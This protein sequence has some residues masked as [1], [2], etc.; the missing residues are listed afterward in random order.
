MVD[1]QAVVIGLLGAAAASCAA[2]VML[3]LAHRVPP[4]DR[5]V[6]DT[7]PRLLRVFAPLIRMLAFYLGPRLSVGFR[8]RSLRQLQAAELDLVFLPQEWLA[9]RL[10]V[11]LV[12]IL[13][14]LLAARLGQVGSGLLAGVGA[15]VFLW[16]YSARWLGEKRAAVQRRVLRDLP[17]YLDVLTLAVEAG[18]SLTV[19]IGW[20][21]EKTVDGPLRRGF[22]RALR[23]VRAG[24]T[25]IDALR[26]FEHRFAMPAITSLVS[27]LVSAEQTGASVGQVLRAQAEQR[28]AERFARAEKLA[29]EAPVKMLGPLVLCIFPCTFIVLGFPIATQLAR[30]FGS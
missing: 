28:G 19:A 30:Q 1:V 26:A 7:A 11:S 27:A 25:R 23:E 22:K 3:R 4:T 29:M 9:T 10:V 13:A 2:V 5:A 21:V 6:L 14:V 24:R 20:C 15:G 12:G 16:W 17:V 8:A 18:A